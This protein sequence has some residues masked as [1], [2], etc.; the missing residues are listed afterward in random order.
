VNQTQLLAVAALSL[1]AGSTLLLSQ[2]RWFG[3]GRWW[4][5]WRRTFREGRRRAAPASWCPRRASDR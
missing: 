2:I 5:A 4:T 1:F 3:G